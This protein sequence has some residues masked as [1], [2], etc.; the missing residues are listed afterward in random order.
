MC[1]H[2]ESEEPFTFD[3][4]EVFSD[5]EGWQDHLSGQVAVAL[6]EKSSWT[7]TNS[8][9]TEEIEVIGP[10]SITGSLLDPSKNQ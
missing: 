8:P 1:Y 3:T 7:F 4:F 6:T 2:R 5:D 9:S 10:K